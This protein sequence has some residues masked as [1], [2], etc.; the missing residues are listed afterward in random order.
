MRDRLTAG[1]QALDLPIQVRILVPQLCAVVKADCRLQSFTSEL[2]YHGPH[3][4]DSQ[5]DPCRTRY[6]L[7]EHKSSE[8]DAYQGEYRDVDSEEFRKITFIP[9]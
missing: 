2:D 1:L 4:D 7:S 3:N 6:V 9:A 8:Q 5:A